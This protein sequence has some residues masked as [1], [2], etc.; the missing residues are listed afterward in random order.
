MGCRGHRAIERKNSNLEIRNS[1]QYL[2]T[3][4]QMTETVLCVIR[5]RDYNLVCLFMTLEH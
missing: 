4:I 3:K 1:K 2:M 5:F